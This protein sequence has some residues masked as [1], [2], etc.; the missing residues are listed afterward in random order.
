MLQAIMLAAIHATDK[1]KGV[2]HFSDMPITLA[3]IDSM[4]KSKKTACCQQT[5]GN[6]KL[7]G[8]L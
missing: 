1:N 8:N 2:R 7:A 5:V 4:S 3:D 6:M